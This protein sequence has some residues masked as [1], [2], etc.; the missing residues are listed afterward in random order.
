MA[1]SIVVELDS[2][3]TINNVD[4]EGMD[5]REVLDAVERIQEFITKKG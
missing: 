3:G 2:E 1:L 4:V 5:V